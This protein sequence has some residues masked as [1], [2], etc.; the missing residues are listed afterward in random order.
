M[1]NETI[2]RW[3]DGLISTGE[4]LSLIL[5]HPYASNS[6]KLSA[7]AKLTVEINEKEL[8][9]INNEVLCEILANESLRW[10]HEDK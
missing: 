10:E 1:F 8:R 7:V 5:T 2:E 6:Q 3:K 9:Q 4:A